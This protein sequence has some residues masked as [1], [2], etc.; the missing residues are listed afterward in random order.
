MT[1]GSSSGKK[2]DGGQKTTKKYF[3]NAERNCQLRSLNPAKVSLKSE[4]EIKRFSDKQRLKE[5][6]NTL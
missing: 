5:F 3:L 1:A 2:K 4:A 6:V